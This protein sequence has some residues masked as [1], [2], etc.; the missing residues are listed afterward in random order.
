MTKQVYGPIIKWAGGKRRVLNDLLEH[1]PEVFERYYEPFL[2][3]GVLFFAL[4]NKYGKKKKYF[5][6]DA[7]ELLINMYRAVASNHAKVWDELE[8]LYGCYE[9][10]K[11]TNDCYNRIR[12]DFNERASQRRATVRAQKRQPDFTLAAQFLFLNRTC[13]N[14]LWRV[15]SKG[16]FNVPHGRY[17]RLSKPS[18][19]SLELAAEAL[20]WATLKCSGYLE[21]LS[22]KNVKGKAF[23]YADPPYC[24]DKGHSGFVAYT[25]GGFAD[26]DQE[27]LCRTL[28]RLSGDDRVVLISNSASEKAQHIYGGAFRLIKVSVRRS[29][30]ASKGARV[31]LNEALFISK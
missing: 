24:V 22:K 7:N 21:A 30:A 15:N 28:K 13:F 26:A 12:S 6:S 14:G 3:S 27:K 18:K 2:G 25:G 1:C 17:K 4:F 29:I 16:E 11:R 20:A 31:R 5:L 10:S 19:A 23:V 8:R 9:A